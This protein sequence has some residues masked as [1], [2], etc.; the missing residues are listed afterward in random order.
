MNVNFPN[1]ATATGT[2][3]S[4]KQTSD[5]LPERESREEPP[6][7]RRYA[8]VH[9]TAEMTTPCEKELSAPTAC[10]AELPVPIITP[11]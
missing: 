5:N 6:L 9:T 2:I 1:P 10:R 8:A 3:A 4:M 7:K 11:P